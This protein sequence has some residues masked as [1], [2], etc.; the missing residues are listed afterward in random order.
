MLTVARRP[1]E[2]SAVKRLRSLFRAILP[3]P[4]TRRRPEQQLSNLAGLTE[5]ANV[6]PERPAQVFYQVEIN[7][8]YETRHDLI[9]IDKVRV[10]QRYNSFKATVGKPASGSPAI[11]QVNCPFY[12]DQLR[13]RV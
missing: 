8:T 11:H 10:T 12:G 4:L 2:R 6:P 7:H 13:I 9:S 3:R 1:G 5:S